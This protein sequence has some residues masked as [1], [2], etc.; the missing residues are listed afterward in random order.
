MARIKLIEARK[1]RGWT[2]ED[3]AEHVGISRAYYTN[4]EL[5][6]KT[7]SLRVAF[8]IAKAL[9][10]DIDIIFFDD[11]VPFRDENDDEGVNEFAQTQAG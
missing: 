11:D 1:A 7:P 4:I 5:G 8:M 3:V 9:N 10:R 2:Q 6:R